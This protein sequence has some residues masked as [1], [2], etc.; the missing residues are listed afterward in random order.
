MKLKRADVIALIEQCLAGLNQERPP[1]DP[2][3]IAEDTPLLG[4]DSKLDSL[5][6]VAFVADLEEQLRA[7]TGCDLVLVG[8]IDGSGDH[9]FRSVSALADRIVE[10]SAAPP[11]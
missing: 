10:L 2:I 1:E 4:S 9:P 11:E 6:F 8:E 3:P 7:S 5:A